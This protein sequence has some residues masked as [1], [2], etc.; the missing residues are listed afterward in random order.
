MLT[1]TELHLNRIAQG[2]VSEVEGCSW[3][4][5]QSL[6]GKVQTLGVLARFCQQAHPLAED[7][8]QAIKRS[9]LKPSFTPCVLLEQAIR[10][11]LALHKILALPIAEQE[12]TF[13]LL[14]ALYS[15]ADARRRIT[16]CSE[17]CAHAWHNLPAL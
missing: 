9:G 13:R 5:S 16:H 17:G 8:A 6:E 10:P 11:E 2:Q 12:K 7:V 14:I 15:I 3:F 4:V 1:A